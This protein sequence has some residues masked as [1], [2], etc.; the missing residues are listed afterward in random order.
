[1]FYGRCTSSLFALMVDKVC[2]KV[3]GWKGKVLSWGGKLTLLR[4][5][6]ASIPIYLTSV[7]RPPDKVVHDLHQLFAKIFWE[8]INI[9]GLLGRKYAFILMKGDWES[10]VYLMFLSHSN[11]KCYGES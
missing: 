5:V 1:M 4:S 11:V 7:I 8:N 2:K 9:T 3:A 6:L 10:E